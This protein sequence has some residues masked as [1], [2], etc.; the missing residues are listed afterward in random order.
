MPHCTSSKISSA[1]VSLQRARTRRGTRA[2]RSTRAADALH[3]LDD[4]GRRI[5]AP[6]T[7]AIGREVAARHELDVERRL[8]EAVPLLRRA[9]GHGARRGGA[10]VKAALDR[11]DLA[12]AR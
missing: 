11:D 1:P 5:V 3:R 2:P 10:A 8:R 6:T 9:P 4:H 7:R 12:P